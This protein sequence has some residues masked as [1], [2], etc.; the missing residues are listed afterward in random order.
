MCDNYPIIPQFGA[1]CWFNVIL[2]ACCYSQELRKLVKIKSYKWDKTNSFLNFLKTILKYSYTN[3]KKIREMFYKQKPEYILF[4]YLNYFDKNLK[5]N[6]RLMIH[7]RSNDISMLVYYNITYI[8]T[9]IRNI[10]INCLDICILDNKEY[11]VDFYKNIELKYNIEKLDQK[12]Y[13]FTLTDDIKYEFNTKFKLKSN[14][15]KANL[16]EIPEVILIQ[17]R[18]LFSLNIPDKEL[19]K[20]TNKKFKIKNINKKNYIEYKGYKYKLDGCLLN[21]YNKKNINH[22]ILGLTCNNKRY[23]YNSFNENYKLKEKKHCKLYKFNWDI[24]KNTEFYFNYNTCKIKK[25]N[26]KNKIKIENKEQTYSFNKD[27]RIL[28]YVK[29]DDNNDDNNNDNNNNDNND[30][31]YKSLSNKQEMVNS[32]Y[33]IRNLNISKLAIETMLINLGY[34]KTYLKNKSRDFLLNLLEKNLKIK[35]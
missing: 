22:V 30:D 23:I 25:I 27:Y 20:Y 2:T 34:K 29:I 24:N 35:K 9:F 7:H 5:E 19:Y 1:T 11:L 6:M 15:K 13:S 21:N 32:F 12:N 4:K 10:G 31:E 28:I 14:I 18:N 17:S 26:K 8:I 16:K 33:D 3:D